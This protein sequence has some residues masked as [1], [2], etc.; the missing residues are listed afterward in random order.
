MSRS[1]IPTR[2]LPE[3]DPLEAL[4]SD[5]DRREIDPAALAWLASLLEHG[6]RAAGATH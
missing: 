6:E 4:V 5:A 2:T 1:D 3:T